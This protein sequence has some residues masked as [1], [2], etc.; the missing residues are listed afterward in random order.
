MNI[1]SRFI[2]ALADTSAISFGGRDGD[3]KVKFEV[4][5][6]EIA[7]VTKLALL[8][9]KTFRVTVELGDE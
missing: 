2:A 8:V 7:E 6:S 9:G 5:A 4:P 1:I 3:A